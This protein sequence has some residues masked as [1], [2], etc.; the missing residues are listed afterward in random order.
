MRK[1]PN[2]Q[3]WN[4]DSKRTFQSLKTRHISSYFTFASGGYIM[5]INPIAI[6][7]FVVPTETV[8]I[9]SLKLGATTA[10]MIPN[11]MAANIHNVKYRSKKDNFFV[12]LS[13]DKFSTPSRCFLTIAFY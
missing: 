4:K 3:F 8:S 11:A 9:T 6:G 1:G 2:N 7:I 5:T 12:T 10:M 13:F